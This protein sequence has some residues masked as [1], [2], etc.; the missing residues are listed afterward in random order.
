MNSYLWLHKSLSGVAFIAAFA[1]GGVSHFGSVSAEAADTPAIEQ[2]YDNQDPWEPFNEKMFW[3]NRQVD[4]FILKPIATGYDWVLPDPAQK[5]VKSSIDNLNVVRRLT[6]NL[7][8]GK[9]TGATREAARFTINSTIGVAGLF[10]I[11]KDGF[12]IKQS[13]G[14]TGQTLGYYGVGPGPYLVLPF[15]PVTTLRDGI[16]RIADTAMHPLNYFI[17]I[18]AT[19]GISGTDTVN[20]RSLNLDKFERVEE[21]VVDLYGAV[22][23]A[24]LQRREAKIKE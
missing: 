19:L 18:G 10:D 11:A 5:S 17:P 1:I 14:D 22:R 3:F 7:L 6:N 4:R 24:Y 2:R 16:G 9:A 21:S 13:D 12:G 23:D 15:L 20:E 8:Q